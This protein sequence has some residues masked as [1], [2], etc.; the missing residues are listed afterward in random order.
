LK[1][2]TN[3]FYINSKK[4]CRDLLSYINA[5]NYVYDKGQLKDYSKKLYA[6][7]LT[8]TRDDV[9]NFFKVPEDIIERKTFVRIYPFFLGRTNEMRIQYET[10]SQLLYDIEEN[11]YNLLFPEE[12]IENTTNYAIVD[13]IVNLEK[14]KVYIDY[15]IIKEF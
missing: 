11:Y 2:L 9:L 7:Y 13:Q 14:L 6:S 8:A 15:R 12:F 5:P 3:T 10:Q 1:I 4:V